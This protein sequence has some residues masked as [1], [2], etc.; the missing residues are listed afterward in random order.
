MLIINLL[1]GLKK[2]CIHQFYFNS[3]NN[4]HTNDKRLI[5][6]KFICATVRNNS[7]IL[8]NIENK[9]MYEYIMISLKSK[10]KKKKINSYL[11][12]SEEDFNQINEVN[13]KV[14]VFLNSNLWTFHEH[15]RKKFHLRNT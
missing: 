8:I 15:T 2:K 6:W 3:F 11:I 13:N 14:I 10:L 12:E 4:L 1:K 7:I 9:S 5:L